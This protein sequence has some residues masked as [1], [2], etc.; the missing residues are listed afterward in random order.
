MQRAATRS[1]LLCTRTMQLRACLRLCTCTGVPASAQRGDRRP[2]PTRERSTLTS[3]NDGGAHR[4]PSRSSMPPVP[5]DP[6]P[7]T[8]HCLPKVTE[9]FAVPTVRARRP[10]RWRARGTGRNL[11]PVAILLRRSVFRKSIIF[12]HTYI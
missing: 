6:F 10:R 12:F 7:L 5:S 11:Y 9:E 8:V 4:S 3:P 1:R 2:G